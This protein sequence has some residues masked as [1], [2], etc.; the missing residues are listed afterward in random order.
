MVRRTG[1]TV[2]TYT[3]EELEA[4][5]NDTEYTP[6][7]YDLRTST[8]KI[9]ALEAECERLR[10]LLPSGNIVWVTLEKWEALQKERDQLR[11]QV[12]KMQN[13]RA[14]SAYHAMTGE[15]FDE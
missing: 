3:A 2:T 5:A 10:G 11:A 7:A 9:A 4:I 13:D 8:E 6:P 15:W 14:E 1:A 12:A